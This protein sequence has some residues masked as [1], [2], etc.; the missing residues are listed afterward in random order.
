[1]PRV[2]G[3]PHAI[4]TAEKHHHPPLE[5]GCILARR[6]VILDPLIREAE[7]VRRVRKDTLHGVH[8]AEHLQTITIDDLNH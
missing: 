6:E 5:E 8:I 7:V 1:M 4:R 2:E 3:Q